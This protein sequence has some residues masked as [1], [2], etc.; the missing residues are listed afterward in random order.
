MPSLELSASPLELQREFDSLTHPRHVASM[1]DIKYSTLIYY[2]YR[3][4][5]RKYRQF[6]IAKKAGGDRTIAEPVAGLKA[7]QLKLS[8]VLDAI[9]QPRPSVHG[10]VQGRSI[11]TNAQLHEESDHIL[12]LDL[13]DFFPSINFGRVRGLFMAQPYRRP[14]EVATVLAQICCFDNALPQ[15]APTSPVVSNMIC[16][17]LDTELQRLARRYRCVYSRY[18][19]DITFSTRRSHFPRSLAEKDG[20]GPSAPVL[21][22]PSLEEALRR[23]GFAVNMA[24]VRLRSKQQRQEV[25]GLLVNRRVNVP[26]KLVRQVRAMLHAWSTYGYEAAQQ[27][28][29]DRYDGK[30]R[31]SFKEKPIFSMVVKGKID[32]I[33]MVK[34]KDDPVYRGL[35]RRYAA[36]VDGFVVPAVEDQGPNHLHRYED[37]IWVLECNETDNQGTAFMLRDFGLITCN[38][39]LGTATQAFQPNR[40]NAKYPVRVISRDRDIDLAILSITAAPS[41]AFESSGNTA[42]RRGTPITVTGYPR[43]DRGSSL[44][45]TR[46]EIA[47]TQ[48]WFGFD[49]FRVTCP[50]VKGAS[51]APVFDGYRRVVGIAARGSATVDDADGADHVVVPIG[52]LRHLVPSQS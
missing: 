18:A 39:V 33:G 46:G 23:N 26:R 7:I 36:Q 27:E 31:P 47:G 6:S 48:R 50:I 52:H 11:A 19:D 37:G 44:W 30:S 51:G 28:F 9:Y 20:I 10:F 8:Q 25:T 1:L 13:E 12:N 5:H 38:H 29:A 40:P 22:G 14:P 3:L 21:L 34:G 42:P 24:K 41:F 4:G 16:S 2:L 15:G 43:W 17:R 49:R 35:L 32:F 45:E